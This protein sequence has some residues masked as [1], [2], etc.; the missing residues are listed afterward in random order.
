MFLAAVAALYRARNA[1]ARSPLK[2]CEVFCRILAQA[3]RGIGQAE[4]LQVESDL[5]YL[6]DYPIRP[7]DRAD[8]APRIGQNVGPRR[9]RR[10]A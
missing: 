9:P 2:T 10:A 6:R 4:G 8:G 7:L 3:N 1:L 5:P